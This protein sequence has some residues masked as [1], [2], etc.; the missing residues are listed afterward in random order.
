MIWNWLVDPATGVV[1]RKLDALDWTKENSV[2]WHRAYPLPGKPGQYFDGMEDPGWSVIADADTGNVEVTRPRPSVQ[3]SN[4]RD[5]FRLNADGTRAWTFVVPAQPWLTKR[6]PGYR[7]MPGTSHE[8]PTL[9]IGSYADG[10][11][12]IELASGKLVWHVPGFKFEFMDGEV[13]IGWL[14]TLGCSLELGM[15]NVTTGHI[16]HRVSLPGFR[17]YRIQTWRNQYLL[18]GEHWSMTGR[19]SP[20]FLVDHNGNSLL[21]TDEP[22]R[23]IEEL[24]GDYVVASNTEVLRLSPSWTGVCCV[25]WRYDISDQEEIR[26]Y[27]S[28]GLCSYW[29]NL[30][31]R[32]S[33]KGT[34]LA[35]G[36]ADHIFAVRGARMTREDS[37]VACLDADT[38]KARWRTSLP[39]VVVSFDSAKSPPHDV[40]YLELRGQELVVVGQGSAAFIEV[41]DANTGKRLRRW[42]YLPDVR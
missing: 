16:L 39:P 30:R 40:F 42:E 29:V 33:R 17:S 22:L 1:L 18:M 36:S 32:N 10:T 31:L 26:Y 9:F 35:R 13:C 3:R 23:S 5:N 34:A 19:F 21:L 14:H 15:L 37:E 25:R 24:D 38:G 2:S 28:Q 11:R 7:L 20:S 41:L 27:E 4:A 12:G 8:T 6:L